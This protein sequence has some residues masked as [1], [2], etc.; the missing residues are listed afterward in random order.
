MDEAKQIRV[1]VA[2][3]TIG[4]ITGVILVHDFRSIFDSVEEIDVIVIE[5]LITSVVK[6]K[7]NEI[8]DPIT[9][10]V[11]VVRVIESLKVPFDIVPL[12]LM[13]ITFVG[14]KGDLVVV[15]LLLKVQGSLVKPIIIIYKNA[16]YG[17]K[18]RRI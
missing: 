17:I 5:D 18:I 6:E 9:I 7:V 14:L 13:L 16:I 10:R 15:K 2:I 11:V 4:F 1:V 3:Q 12:K 8:V